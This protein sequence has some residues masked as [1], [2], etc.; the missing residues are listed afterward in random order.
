MAKF[1]PLTEEY[2]RRHVPSIYATEHDGLRSE[3]YTFVSTKEVIDILADEN[4]LPHRAKQV[5]QRFNPKKIYQS[6]GHQKHMVVFRHTD[7]ALSFED[8]RIKVINHGDF[9]M[10]KARIYPEIV[11]FNSSDGTS[12]IKFSG[13]LYALICENGLIIPISTVGC[14]EAK[15]QDFD[16]RDIYKGARLF[17][18]EVPKL[19]KVVESWSTIELDQPQQ[20]EMASDAAFLRWGEDY[21]I[22]PEQLLIPRRKTDSGKDLWTTFNKIQE[23]VI[24]G[25]FKAER[26]K[27]KVRLITNIQQTKEINEGLWGVAEGMY[28]ELAA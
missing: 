18:H 12:R 7:E 2:M 14:F 28:K 1:T 27:R 3:R 25:G 8:P 11:L 16:P 10:D 9:K 21:P 13:G 4:W 23:N 26:S 5:Q 17:V 19:L 6:T 15:H 22:V 24:K 20:N